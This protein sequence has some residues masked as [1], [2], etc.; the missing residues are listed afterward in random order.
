VYTS[1]SSAIVE[2]EFDMIGTYQVTFNV[3]DEEDEPITGAVIT[4]DGNAITGYVAEALTGNHT[5]TVT[6]EGFEPKSGTVEVEGENV[7]VNVTM[8]RITYNVTF[9]VVDVNSDPIVDAIITL[10]GETNVAGE[11][12]FTKVL[13]GEREYTVVKDGY[14]TVSGTIT[15][16]GNA[17]ENVTMATSGIGANS[18]SSVTLY[19]NPFKDEITISN[20]TLIKNVQ[21][22]NASGQ[23]V[24]DIAFEGKSI[25]TSDLSNGI[26]FIVVE[27]FNGNRAVHKMIKK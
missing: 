19:P 23:K 2:T 26:Y 5:Y 14:G 7:T 15:V 1:G 13:P 20:P 17:T 4:F 10:D 24:R 11:Y 27:D 16:T 3:I 18:L 21:V 6:C 8:V 25:V 12:E 22:M 9:T